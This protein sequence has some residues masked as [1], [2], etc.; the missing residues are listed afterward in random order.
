MAKPK[1]IKNEVNLAL[2]ALS[3]SYQINYNIYIFI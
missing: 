3:Y 2:F 1:A